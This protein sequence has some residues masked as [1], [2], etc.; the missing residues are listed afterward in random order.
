MPRCTKK[1]IDT[2]ATKEYVAKSY[3]LTEEKLTFKNPSIGHCR[4][5][6]YNTAIVCTII[7]LFKWTYLSNKK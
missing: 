3:S 1:F 5:Y 6:V 2:W 7:N 4:L